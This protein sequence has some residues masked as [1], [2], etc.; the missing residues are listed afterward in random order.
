MRQK[1]RSEANL[2]ETFFRLDF[3]ET[4]I[5]IVLATIPSLLFSGL[6]V[7]VS[8]PPYY[9]LNLKTVLQQ[10]HDYEN[11]FGRLLDDSWTTLGRLLDE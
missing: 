3:F 11:S 1:K 4:T 7:F 2:T 9:F 6:C 8:W 5:V 10:T